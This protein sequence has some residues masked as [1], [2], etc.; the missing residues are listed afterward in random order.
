MAFFLLKYL[1]NNESI[2]K[3]VGA[4]LTVIQQILALLQMNKTYFL[5]NLKLTKQKRHSADSQ[6]SL[7]YV[8]T[9][10]VTDIIKKL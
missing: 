8:N 6:D 10:K 3:I 1:N 5:K 2:I 7:N 4:Y 9:S